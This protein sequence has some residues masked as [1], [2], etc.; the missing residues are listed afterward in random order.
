MTLDARPIFALTKSINMSQ[1]KLKVAVIGLGNLGRIVASNLVKGGRKVIIAD[2]NPE[3][4]K[5]LAAELGDLA[6]PEELAVAVREAD[7]IVPAIYFNAILEFLK[8]YAQDLDG[9][10]II[11][12]SNPI[13]P[14]DKGGFKKIIGQ[15]ES[16]GELILA[17]LPKGA[18]LAKA[19]GSLGAVSLAKAA[20]ATPARSVLFYA[21]STTAINAAIEELIRDSGFDPVRIGGIDKSIR[22]EVFG[23]LHE[24]GALGKT[25]TAAEAAHLS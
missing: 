1:A 25:V 7:I 2:R 22:I 4:A 15:Q 17:V 24:L 20:F 9:K 13:A 19:L 23:D 16:A 21:T 18:S 10:I 8:T 6:Q 3:K 11:D 14:D 5:A 12:P